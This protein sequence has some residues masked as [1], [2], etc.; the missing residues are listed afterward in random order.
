[1]ATRYAQGSKR[2]SISTDGRST[3]ALHWVIVGNAEADAVIV[4]SVS[5]FELS[6]MD[7]A[8]YMD[9]VPAEVLNLDAE[10]ERVRAHGYKLSEAQA[11]AF[12]PNLKEVH[13]RH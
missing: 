10:I 5:E 3:R 13:Y 6:A 11:R 8:A 12:F 7:W 9:A 1:M 4:A 2:E